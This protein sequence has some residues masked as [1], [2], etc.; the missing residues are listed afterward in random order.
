ME[1]AG[2]D[3]LGQL[4]RVARAVDIRG[5]LAFRVGGEIVDRGKMEEV[6]DLAG[7]RLALRRS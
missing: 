2:L 5:D 6:L 3:L 7:Q 4:Q 1:T